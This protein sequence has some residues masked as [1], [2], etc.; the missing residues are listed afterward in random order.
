MK[1]GFN[2]EKITGVHLELTT[3]CNAMCPMCNRNFKGKIR[4]NLPILELS[5]NDIKT[6]LTPDF[7]SQLKLVSLCGVYGEPICNSE[8]KEIIKYLY[9]CNEKLDIDLYTNGSLYGK[10]YWEDLA[11]IMKNHNGTVI[12]GIDGLGDIHSLHR[13][14]TNFEKVIENAKS[15][16]AAGGNAQWDYIVFKHNETQV[17]EAKKLSEE[18]GF[19]SFQIKKT[20]R[21]LKN[22]YELDE[23]LDSTIL[24]YGKHPVFNSD[25]GIDYYIELPDNQKYRNSSENYLFELI[26]EY[27]DINKYLDKNIIDCDAIKSGGIFISA[28]GE[29]FPCCTVYQQVCYKTIHGVEDKNELNEYY[30]YIKDV[31][32]GLKY[33]IKNIIDGYFF[34]ELYECFNCSSIDLGK[35][36]SC[37]RACGKD[38]DIHANGHSTKIKYKG[39]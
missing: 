31:L 9:F 32:S 18:L 15:Y 16:I 8:L 1:N 17:E 30:L 23:K 35:P 33:P 20:S 27:G 26:E 29:V 6:I 24:E 21:F 37:A 34:T 5:L 39:R 4:E 3:K 10:S 13:C 38:L 36:K 11:H 28:T 19:K 25:G 7:V 22:L 14:N 12:F 2:Y